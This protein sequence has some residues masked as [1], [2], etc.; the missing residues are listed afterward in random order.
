[1]IDLGQSPGDAADRELREAFLAHYVRFWSSTAGSAAPL[2]PGE[3]RRRGGAIERALQE[4]A[5]G[6]ERLGLPADLDAIAFVGHGRSNGHAFRNGSAVY[7]WF[8]LEQYP[9]SRRIRAFVP[10]ELTHAVHYAE[11]P[12]LYFETQDEQGST[13][14]QLV[15]EGIAT[16]A[17]QVLT[18]CT[19]ME[20]VW[21]DFLAAEDAERWMDT[22][23]AGLP[24]LAAASLEY[25]NS[26]L[27]GNPLFAYS[28]GEPPDRNRGGYLLGL[29]LAR[30][31][32]ERRNVGLAD[33]VQLDRTA[34]EALFR[35][36]AEAIAAR[37]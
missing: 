32:A 21:A 20:A 22:A 36:G 11:V 31:A 1:M 16:L 5:A 25:W 6:L 37:G 15:T 12:D 29:E 8:A 18:G 17:A 9:S 26:S 28:E 3:A 27:A 2:D 33:L 4:A 7:P 23:V 35:E 34:A 19:A 30:W 13:S 24:A 14:R 10:H